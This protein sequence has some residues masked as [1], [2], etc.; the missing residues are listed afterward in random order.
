MKQEY[1][2]VDSKID[3]NGESRAVLVK[4]NTLKQDDI[5]KLAKERYPEYYSIGLGGDR[6]G[7]ERGYQLAKENTYTEEQ[8]RE[9]IDMAREEKGYASYEYT[10]NEIIQSLKQPK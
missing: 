1:K 7:F 2:I 4:S 5:E 6:I 3:N 10:E 8:V 9:A